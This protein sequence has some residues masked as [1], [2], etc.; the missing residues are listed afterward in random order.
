MTASGRPQLS[1]RRFS[2]RFRL[3]PRRL[4]IRAVFAVPAVVLILLGVGMAARLQ[5]LTPTGPYPVGR[6]HLTW[7]DSSRSETHTADQSDDRTV[8]LQLWFPAQA[9]TGQPGPYLP[10]RADIADGLVASGELNRLSVWGLRFVRDAARDGARI[11][12]AQRSY[13]VVLLSPGNATNVAFYATIAQELASRSYIVVGIDHP[14]Q[15]AA[16]QLPDGTVATYHAA[17]DRSSGAGSDG[18]ATKV[19]E[20][21]DDVRFV[22]DGLAATHGS[23]LEGRMDLGRV[24]ILGHSNGG[25]TAAEACRQDPR[26]GACM[27]LDGQAAGGPFSISQQG[28]APK[29]PFMYLTKETALHPEVGRRFE[30]AGDGTYRV[31][32]PAAEHDEFADGARFR[33]TLNPLGRSPEHVLTVSRGFAASFFDIHLRGAGR[34]AL[35][36]VPAPTNV[37]VNVY[38][39]GDQP[40]LPATG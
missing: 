37:Y 26:L 18:V 11:S 25:L 28:T 6:Q 4:L 13:P 10:G 30:A 16:V 27:N 7:V 8:A 14:Y 24:G 1:R 15:V 20:R 23:L 32:V 22:L 19:Q 36:Q 9:G 21:V 35:G 34:A 31:V 40:P 33:P 29:Q 3:P 39:L 38:P 17:A 2:A 12:P 5:V